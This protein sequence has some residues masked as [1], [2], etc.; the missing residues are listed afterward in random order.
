MTLMVLGFLSFFAF[1]AG[2]FMLV[3]G[4]YLF[5]NGLITIL[6]GESQLAILYSF[7]YIGLSLV[8]WHWSRKIIGGLYI[9]IKEIINNKD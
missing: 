2:S 5:S 9:S 3:G 7:L 6:Q 1:I 4:I 8:F